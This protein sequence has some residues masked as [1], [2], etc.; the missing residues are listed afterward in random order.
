MNENIQFLAIIIVVVDP[1]IGSISFKQLCFVIYLSYLRFR[2]RKTET[3]FRSKTQC[4]PKACPNT[5][6][7]RF[8][9]SMKMN[10]FCEFSLRCRYFAHWLTDS[11]LNF[12]TNFERVLRNGLWKERKKAVKLVHYIRSAPFF[13]H[14]CQ[15]AAFL[16]GR[17]RFWFS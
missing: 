8:K 13:P 2:R 16:P 15:S 14:A 1:P 9:L 4:P 17:W 3:L 6:V 7:V 12:C 11:S 5:Q 10:V